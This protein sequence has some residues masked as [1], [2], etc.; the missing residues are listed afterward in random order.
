MEFSP[1]KRRILAG[2]ARDNKSID[3]EYAEKSLLLSCCC[4]HIFY[5]DTFRMSISQSK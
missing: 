3:V 2:T 1:T 5:S 4:L